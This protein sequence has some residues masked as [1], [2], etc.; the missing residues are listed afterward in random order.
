M[1]LLTYLEENCSVRVINAAKSALDNGILLHQC[2][3]IDFMRMRNVGYRTY[4]EFDKAREDWKKLY[5]EPFII[6]EDS[7]EFH[8]RY[9]N[10]YII[11][12]EH[13]IG[14]CYNQE[15][16]ESVVLLST[17]MEIGCTPEETDKVVS[18]IFKY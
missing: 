13:V 5:G 12:K 14:V 1:D 16:T 9:G 10:L 17:G 2:K 7:I 11:K 4:E 15:N 6:N 3:K 18:A 8:G